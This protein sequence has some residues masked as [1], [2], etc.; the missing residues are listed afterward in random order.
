MPTL[1]KHGDKECS[2]SSDDE[3]RDDESDSDDETSDDECLNIPNLV[4]R[5]MVHYD[6]ID[7]EKW[8]DEN[9]KRIII[10]S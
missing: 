6:S 3:T 2:S 1:F 4:P 5:E 7:V 8:A 10:R 9:Q